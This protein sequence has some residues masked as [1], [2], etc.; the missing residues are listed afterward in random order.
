MI[1][2]GTSEPASTPPTWPTSPSPLITTG[3]SPLARG[4]ARLVDR[5]L[6]RLGPDGAVR[7]ASPLERALELGQRLER[8]PAC[9]GGV[10]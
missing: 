4:L 5:V 7:D 10:D 1:P 8:P 6:E 2:S 3:I 9:G